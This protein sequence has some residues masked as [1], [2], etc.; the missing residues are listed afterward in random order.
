MTTIYFVRHCESDTSIHDDRNRPLT[1]KGLADRELV[2]TF[3]HDKGINIV[4][5]SPY[6]RVYDT[7]YDFAN[8]TGLQIQSIEDFRE[9][10]VGNIWLPG[11][12]FWQYIK[13]KW[14]DFSFKLSDGE[15]LAD[16]QNRNIAALSEVL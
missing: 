6:K 2:T 3:L 14:S 13:R 4:L 12:E 15:S 7:I 5:S 11:D 16:V 8:K 1:A 9:R 10:K